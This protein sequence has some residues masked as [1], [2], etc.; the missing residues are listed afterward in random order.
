MKKP[1]YE[2]IIDEATK[3]AN[4]LVASAKKE[5]DKKTSAL[6]KSIT[7][8]NTAFTVE[9]K[10]D[11]KNKIAAHEE[12]QAR[13]LA[14]FVEQTRQEIVVDVFSEAY[15]ALCK[16]TKTD[17]LKYV[18]KLLANQTVTG[19]EAIQVS[20]ANYDKYLTAF[21]STKDAN[22]L[23][24]LNSGNK[25]YKFKLSKE[26]VLINE[27]FLLSGV[28]FDLIFD[29][30]EIVDDYQRVHEQNIYKELFGDE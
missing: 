10:L 27:G 22:S 2:R 11:A 16:L 19:T 14:N 17:L 1:I 5:A 26:P 25:Q 4:A 8:Q 9:A 7:E 29:F 13:D 6:Q 12:R 24:L 15:N 20:K 30:K 21:S 23:D 28:K 3:E 18:H